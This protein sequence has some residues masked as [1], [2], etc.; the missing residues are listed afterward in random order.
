MG[1]DTRSYSALAP[2]NSQTP[3]TPDLSTSYPQAS[4]LCPAGAGETP[5]TPYSNSRK[6]A[7]GFGSPGVAGHQSG[8]PEFWHKKRGDKSPLF[9][10]VRKSYSI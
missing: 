10:V 9:R 7:I 4:S 3:Q 1:Q 8:F 2:L 6:M 5:Q